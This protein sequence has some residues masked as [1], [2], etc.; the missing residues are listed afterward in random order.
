VAAAGGS[1]ASI[2]Q[3]ACSSVQCIAATCF[4]SNCGRQRGLHVAGLDAVRGLAA[5]VGVIAHWQCRFVYTYILV[6]TCIGWRSGV[7]QASCL[8]LAMFN[9][10]TCSHVRA[11]STCI[12]S[13]S[14]VQPT[15]SGQA[16]YKLCHPVGSF[17]H[18]Q[19]CMLL[20]LHC[21]CSA[22]ACA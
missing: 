12:A 19:S 2:V 3:H 11:C 8:Q 14:S 20:Q 17:V 10:D 15:A 13:R 9:L 18:Q 21:R 16:S 7:K 4:C 22:V 1:T 6:Y 5:D